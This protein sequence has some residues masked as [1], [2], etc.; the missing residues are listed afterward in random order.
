MNDAVTLAVTLPR[1]V[2]A[3]IVS[4][5]LLDLRSDQSCYALN[6]VIGLAVT[7]AALACVLGPGGYTA[8]RSHSNSK[9]LTHPARG[10]VLGPLALR[11]ALSDLLW[12]AGQTLLQH[13]T[14]SRPL[15]IREHIFDRLF[16]TCL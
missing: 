16:K 3:L 5:E 7:G 15:R 12:R 13:P 1:T 6:C 10:Q 9:M 8:V 14:H 4:K 11:R 2:C